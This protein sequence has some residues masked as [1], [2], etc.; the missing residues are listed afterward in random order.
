MAIT[1]QVVG[2]K[3]SGKTAVVTALIKRL[4][5]ADYRV[6]SIKHDAHTGTMDVPGTDSARM[7]DAGAQQVILTAENQFFFH[8]QGAV[9]SLASLVHYLSG[10]NDFIIIE[11]H[12]AAKY[13][14]IW[15]LQEGESPLAVDC[16]NCLRPPVCLLRHSQI[17]ET[18]L[19]KLVDWLFNYLVEQRSGDLQ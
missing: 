8:Q 15:L 6:A 3:N 7:T 12:K 16:N 18:E 2:H 17:D 5:D 19:P 11:G 1:I 4:T 14:K 9:P 10:A 13:P